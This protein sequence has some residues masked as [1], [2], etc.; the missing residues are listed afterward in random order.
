MRIDV[1]GIIT[2]A[3]S[4]EGVNVTTLESSFMHESSTRSGQQGFALVIN[5]R[6][7]FR[8]FGRQLAI[9]PFSGRMENEQPSRL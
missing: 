2:L 4:D 5:S 8:A 3:Y 7:M 9:A 6:H 1:T